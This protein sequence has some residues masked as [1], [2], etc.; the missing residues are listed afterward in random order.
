MHAHVEGVGHGEGHEEGDGDAGGGGEDRHRVA[1]DEPRP[2]GAE[3][4]QRES[5]FF[6]VS[7]MMRLTSAAAL[8]SA[9]LTSP[10]WIETTMAA[11]MASRHSAAATTGGV[12]S[13]VPTLR[14]TV[15][16]SRRSA[17]TLVSPFVT[18]H[19]ESRAPS[20]PFPTGTARTCH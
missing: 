6:S 15:R 7:A 19:T 9:A 10:P 13:V 5:Y 14:P 20:P 4:T 3:R 12:H 17:G 18:F 11:P 1:L 16:H 2:P 8:L